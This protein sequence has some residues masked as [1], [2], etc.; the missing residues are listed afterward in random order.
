MKGKSSICS[1]TRKDGPCAV[2]RHGHRYVI[3]KQNPPPESGA[4][5]MTLLKARTPSA[6]PHARRPQWK[7]RAARKGYVKPQ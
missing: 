7:A 6:N 1:V 3:D 5:P 4:R 2:R